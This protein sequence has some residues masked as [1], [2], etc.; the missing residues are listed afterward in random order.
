M[1]EIT[2]R[3]NLDVQQGGIQQTLAGFRAG[4]SLS[5]TVCIHLV[6]RGSAYQVPADCTVTLYAEKPDG[7]VSYSM[8]TVENGYLQHTFTS[9]ELAVPGEVICEVRILSGGSDPVVVS[10]PQFT[11][12][13]EDVLHSDTAIESTNE[14][15]A[16]TEMAA[17]LEGKK[18]AAGEAALAA[19]NAAASA[20]TAAEDA[21]EAA[22]FARLSG[23]VN[24]QAI[25]QH[26]ADTDVH[27]TA[28]EKNKL[29]GI[30]AGANKYEHPEHP[31]KSTGMYKVTVD[32]YGHVS[33]TT[34]VTKEDIVALGISAEGKTYT[35]ATTRASGLMSKEDKAKLDQYGDVYFQPAQTVKIYN[36]G[37][38]G[39]PSQTGEDLYF[40]ET[41]GFLN[42]YGGEG[43]TLSE[44]TDPSNVSR[45]GIRIQGAA[46]PGEKGERGEQGKSAY[47]LYVE[48]GGT[49]T[50]PQWLASLAQTRPEFADDITGCTDTSKVYVLP[51]GYIYAYMTR[52]IVNNPNQ[53]DP[54]KAVLNVRFSGSGTAAYNGGFATDYIPV[55]LS[56]ADPYIVRIEG[57]PAGWS[58]AWVTGSQKIVFY[59]ADKSLIK[60]VYVRYQQAA[61]G[62]ST[63]LQYQNGKYICQ[64][65]YT[66]DDN[67]NN[68]A[69]NGVAGAKYVRFGLGI[70]SGAV[71][72]QEDIADIKIYF[73]PLCTDTY[74][75]AWMNTGLAFV[76]ADYEDRILAA[77]T[78]LNGIKG[79][80]E[81]LEP[82]SSGGILPPDYWM[83]A[84]ENKASSI[85]T[86]Q[87]SGMDAFQ[88]VW[89][90]D[91]HG[92]SGYQN[93]NGAGKSSQTNIGKVAQYL[94]NRYNIPL[95]A[96]S[97]DMM[98]QTSHTAVQN[99]YDE[100]KNIRSVL[101]PIP[102]DKLLAVRGNHDGSWGAP[103]NEVYY[104]KHIGN[105]ALYNEVY[106]RQAADWGRVFGKDGTYFYVDSIPGKVRFI[107]LNSNTDGDGSND[108][109]GNAVYN[110]MKNSVYGTQ[111]LAWLADT[112]NSVPDGF[113]VIAMAHQPLSTSR[114]G[115]IM[116]GILS[117][118]K[119]KTSYSETKNTSFQYWGSGLSNAYTYS[120]ASC[121]FTQA[122]GD[123]AAFFYGHIHKD[124][125]DTQTYDFPCISITTAGGDVRDESPVQRTPG[126]ATETAMDVVT[127]DKAAHKI[128]FT[129]FGVGADRSCSY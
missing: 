36:A 7:T 85:K 116:A 53:L 66:G 42:L 21:A 111:Q 83:T 2:Y 99:V 18:E 59:G 89:F 28:A 120:T 19:T 45:R 35:E 117:A 27:V 24:A 64:L 82:G 115:E 77:E 39:A 91:M 112:L 6:E 106:R 29:T 128:Y 43:V 104:L 98:S 47:E 41:E 52:H 62:D 90:S 113:T 61:N 16:L 4:D 46:I 44:Y 40:D 73:D 103:V 11:V 70:N 5:R 12:I 57:L 20:T 95:V 118:Y 69:A 122:K 55:D 50:Q 9:G 25:Q 14:Y 105:R 26:S 110:S 17:G 114:D 78:E 32:G 107:M 88:F 31:A 75:T 108:A 60:A 84:I 65:G 67:G 38:D 1:K 100:Y 13:V 63:K 15:S 51:D 121:D 129:R 30:E 48:N 93:T 37:T 87:Q 3:I 34:P 125:I 8:C 124:S 54:T 49:L 33:Y 119:G 74:E 23:M 68:P 22:E 72:T 56:A 71:V 81:T 109:N 94:C 80:I 96:A 102:S 101:S 86:A 126:T 10:C 58:D 76:P 123:F 127:L 79:K 92:V 97:G